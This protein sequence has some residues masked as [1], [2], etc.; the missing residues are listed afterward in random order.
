[1]DE[2]SGVGVRC[3]L[4]APSGIEAMATIDT[5][6]A[7]LVV[8]IWIHDRDD[9]MAECYGEEGWEGEGI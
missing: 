7:I 5:V 1:M 4:L 2:R 9:N 6:L 3:A 8:G